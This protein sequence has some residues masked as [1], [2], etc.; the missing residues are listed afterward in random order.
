MS[1]LRNFDLNLLVALKLLLEEGNVSRAAAK[2]F[3]S[4][5]A[6]SHILQ[7]LRQQLNDPVLVK[8]SKGMKPTERATS[9]LAPFPTFWE[10]L[11]ISLKTKKNLSLRL[12]RDDL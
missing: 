9:L 8:T 12:A 7:R 4:P 2:M 11:K 10:K 6:M 1:E 5:S 3:V